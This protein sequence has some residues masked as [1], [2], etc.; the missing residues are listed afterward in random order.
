MGWLLA[1]RYA[2][3]RFFL[4]SV[5]KPRMQNRGS[6]PADHLDSRFRGNDVILEKESP[7]N[8]VKDTKI[9]GTNSRIYCK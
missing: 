7:E 1:P 6:A 3:Q 8:H 5:Y 2:A 9:V 4:M